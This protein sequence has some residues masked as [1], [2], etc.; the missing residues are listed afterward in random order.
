MASSVPSPAC[1]A[2]TEQPVRVAPPARRAEISMVKG[3]CAVCVVLIHALPFV[4][5]GWWFEG[6]VNRAVYVL[7]ILLGFNLEQWWRA[8]ASTIPSSAPC[9]CQAHVTKHTMVSAKCSSQEHV[10]KLGPAR[11]WA[12]T[13]R[14][15]MTRM[16]GRT[17]PRFLCTMALFWTITALRGFHLSGAMVC[18][19]VF[20]VLPVYGMS[21]FMCVLPQLLLLALFWQ[22][23]VRWARH[24]APALALSALT[25]ILVH[26]YPLEIARRVRAA[27]LALGADLYTEHPENPWSM[28]YYQWIFSPTYSFHLVA[29]LSLASLDRPPPP[30]AAS[31]SPLHS[32]SPLLPSAAS[33]A[34]PSFPPPWLRPVPFLS[35]CL[36]AFLS[37]SFLRFSPV[38]FVPRNA[39]QSLL[40]LPLAFALLGT[41]G[42]LAT[43]AT[44]GYVRNVWQRAGQLAAQWLMAFLCWCGDRS[45]ELYLVQFLVYY[46]LRPPR[47][48]YTLVSTVIRPDQPCV[49]FTAV[50]LACVCVLAAPRVLRHFAAHCSLPKRSPVS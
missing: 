39:W 19:S 24:P 49:T 10:A 23:L 12:V 42:R 47:L 14:A 50:L 26:R 28:L 40:D 43:G 1:S 3:L 9:S 32:F 4:P 7:I 45:W 35:A 8:H 46:I 22:L 25:L 44:T 29:G 21:W 13:V 30:L 37:G 34:P 38:L 20:G 31:A 16:L 5:H 33:P 36:C 48:E 41:A 2:S 11:L 6:L 15:Y 18:Q 27:L 17:W